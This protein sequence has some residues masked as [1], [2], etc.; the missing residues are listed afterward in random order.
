MTERE[1][2]AFQ[3]AAQRSARG[4]QQC[5][6]AVKTPAA[7]DPAR[8]ACDRLGIEEAK[9]LGLVEDALQ[10]AVAENLGKV[11]EGARDRGD[12]NR[13]DRGDVLGRQVSHAVHRDPGAGSASALGVVTSTCL[14]RAPGRRPRIAASRWLS[15]ARGP[16]ARTAASQRPWRPI[17]V[18]PTA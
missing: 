5:M 17:A 9:D 18:C 3:V 7:G 16:H 15:A 4:V 14:R 12:G 6:D 8:G 11:D 10:L 1:E 2:A 13:G